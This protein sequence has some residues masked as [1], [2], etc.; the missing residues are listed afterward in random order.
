MENVDVTPEEP[1]ERGRASRA[2]GTERVQA[3]DLQDEEWLALHRELVDLL[4]SVLIEEKGVHRAWLFG[5][6]ALGTERSGSDVDLVV[7]M[8]DE[9][10]RARRQLRGKLEAKAGRKVDLFLFADLEA[11]RKV[12]VNLREDW[13]GRRR[14][15]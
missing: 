10:L 9:S 1:V 4:R 5:S 13:G 2:L 15:R 3:W 7:D 11:E 12:R 14:I 8:D 6:V